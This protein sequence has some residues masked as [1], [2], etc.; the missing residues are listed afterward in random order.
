[1]PDWLDPKTTLLPKL[2]KEAGY[3][4]AH[5]GKWHLSSSHYECPSPFDYGY[6]RAAIFTGPEPSL[7]TDCPPSM[8]PL[9]KFEGQNPENLTIA[10]VNHAEKFVRDSVGKKPFFLNLW[11]HEAHQDVAAPE[12]VK[13]LYPNIPEP[14]KPTMR[15]SPMPIPKSVEFS[16]S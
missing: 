9:G 5:F 6:D 15:Q 11:I 7:F 12:T 8:D 4:T 2:L 13:A 10:S 3:T 1:M 14:K 16:N